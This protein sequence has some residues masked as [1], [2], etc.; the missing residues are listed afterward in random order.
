MR[1]SVGQAFLPVT[2]GRTRSSVL[3]QPADNTIEQVDS[4]GRISTTTF[5]A[6]VDADAARRTGTADVT[7]VGKAIKC[8]RYDLA[9]WAINGDRAS[10]GTMTAYL[11]ADVPG[12]IV[13]AVISS[14][15]QGQ[16][17]MLLT[18]SNAK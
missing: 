10:G 1:R 6:Q 5:P 17:H 9:M 16:L 11:S 15:G 18:A 13:K 7:A 4:A 3:A 2:G 14:P 8:D 12:G